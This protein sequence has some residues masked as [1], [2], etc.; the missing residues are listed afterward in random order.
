MGSAVVGRRAWG[1]GRGFPRFGFWGRRASFLLLL[2][3]G[4]GVGREEKLIK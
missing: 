2:R 3:R 4:G 1:V